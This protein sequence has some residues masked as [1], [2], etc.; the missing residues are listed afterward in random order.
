MQRVCTRG[1]IKGVIE[2]PASKSAMQRAIACALLA[3]GKSEIKFSGSPC[4]DSQAAGRIAVSLGAKLQW[5][6]NS[7]AIYGSPDFLEQGRL[8]THGAD[9]PAEGIIL[10]CGESGLCIRMFSPLASLLDQKI[11]MKAGGSLIAR[12]MTMMA[13]PFSQVGVSCKTNSGHPPIELRGP[14]RGG[15]IFMDSGGS[16]QFLT[17][18]LMALALTDEGG[19]VELTNPVSTGYLDLT[20]DIC[21]YFG[22]K[23]GI[24]EDHREYSI[25]GRQSYHPATIKIEGDWS[26]GAFL[27]VAAAISSNKGLIIEGLNPASRQ[28]DRSILEALRLAGVKAEH[29]EGRLLV[30]R[31]KLLPFVFDATQC[32]DIFPPLAVLAAAMDGVS[33]LKGI[34]RLSGKESD[35]AKSLKRS[36]G[37]LGIKIDLGNDEMRIFGGT[38][39]GGTVDA[40]EDHRIAMAAATAALVASGPVSVIGSECVEKSWPRFY[41]DLES[42]KN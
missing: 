14:M 13:A 6:S 32:P 10:D 31:E 37:S 23:I 4:A 42:I 5:T 17:G 8:S 39:C 40:C 25:P 1:E 21:G 9:K 18:L 11:I 28:P 29:L 41:E 22:V 24:S 38:L 33:I 36:L 27:A 15:K 30:R 16:S 12:P 7:L 3:A 26:S 20:A 35:R 34:N 19:Q 2:V